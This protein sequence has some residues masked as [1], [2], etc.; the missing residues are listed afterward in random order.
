MEFW[1]L[2]SGRKAPI[3]DPLVGLVNRLLDQQQ[4]KDKQQVELMRSMIHN[5]AEQNQLTRE[6]LG[7]YINTQQNGTSSMDQRLLLAEQHTEW[8]PVAE[9][10]FRLIGLDD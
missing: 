5:Q 6:L 2:V 7:Q 1:K 10:P 8:D 9:D 4:E 3:S